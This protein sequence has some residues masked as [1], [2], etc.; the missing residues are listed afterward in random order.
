MIDVQA[1]FLRQQLPLRRFDYVTVLR[2]VPSKS[3]KV[4]SVYVDARAVP[5]VT[6]NGELVV[7]HVITDSTVVPDVRLEYVDDEGAV[8][9][10]EY[11]EPLSYGVERNQD[12]SVR[13]ADTAL[14]IES[15][16]MDKVEEV[17]VN[18]EPREFAVLSESRAFASLNPT[19]RRVDTVELRGTAQRFSDSAGLDFTLGSSGGKAISGKYKAAGQLVKLLLTTP[20]SNVFDKDIAYGGL[21]DL[22]KIRS[23][24]AGATGLAAMVVGRIQAAS[25]ALVARHLTSN[26]PE[27]EKLVLVNPVSVE[28]VAG[29]GLR[30]RVVLDLVFMDGLTAKLGFISQ[31]AKGAFSA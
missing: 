19:D 12:G 6:Q 31:A 7:F 24:T 17:L 5:F 3:L 10:S 2:V 27:S 13:V 4:G 16:N 30:L 23:T 9:G 20:G 22:T 28:E 14:Y 1:V 25:S 11:K 21:G 15:I 29:V 26:I 18:G 8:L